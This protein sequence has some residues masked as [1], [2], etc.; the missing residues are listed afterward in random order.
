[1]TSSP[2]ILKL[3]APG[4]DPALIARGG[5]RFWQVSF[6][7]FLGSFAT[8][9]LLYCVQPLMPTFTRAFSIFPAA[10][11]LSLSA[12]TGVLAVAMIFAGTLSDVLGRKTM[13]A[14]LATA[15]AATLGTSF[16][17]NWTTL[18]ALRALTGLALSGIPAVAMAYLV[19]EM[20]RS[21]IGLAMGLYIAGNTLGGMGGRLASAALADVGGW[22]GAIAIVG[23]VSLGCAAAF[24]FA[25]PREQRL[26]PKAV[27]TALLPTIA[28]HFSDPGLR[29]LFALGFLLMGVLVTTYN[30]IGFRLEAAPFSLSQAAIG[31]VYSIYLVGAVASAVMGELAGRYGR[32]RVIGFALA[33]MPIGVVLTLPDNLWLT[34]LG[35]GVIT[36][37]FFGGHSI[38]S[39][40]VGLRAETA[41]AQAS[42]LYLF[43]YY[44]G[45]SL[46]GSV[47]GWVFT[48]GA[49]PGEAAFIGAMSALALLIALKLARVPPPAHLRAS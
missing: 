23:L 11:S 29:Y 13:T 20:D 43:F 21:A 28:M 22:R 4:A 14:S 12:A 47:G 38:A 25:L 18:V 46:A 35:V 39:S 48:L 44:A 49:W 8:F 2:T 17:P 19:E 9:A 15:A 16:S 5:A 30:Y 41:K 37:G 33:F 10:A 7:L 6:A 26:P 32:R 3:E 1:M 27:A 42:A 36:I 40:W 31:L 45:S 34:I 24:A